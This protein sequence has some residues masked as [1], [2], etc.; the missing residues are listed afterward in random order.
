MPNPHFDISI[1]KRKEKQFAIA[2][3]AYQ[4]ND[5]LYS[6]NKKGTGWTSISEK[7]NRG[8]GM[9]MIPIIEIL[10]DFAAGDVFDL[11]SQKSWQTT[12]NML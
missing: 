7:E 3:P 8:Y 12:K 9:V 11:V 10:F 6:E 4:S 2:G 1:V 5:R